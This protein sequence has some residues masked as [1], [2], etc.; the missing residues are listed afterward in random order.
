MIFRCAA[1]TFW[2]TSDGLWAAQISDAVDLQPEIGAAGNRCTQNR[3]GRRLILTAEAARLR[4]LSK[5][6]AAY[7]SRDITPRILSFT[8]Y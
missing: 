4:R 6:F 2:P 3:V 1:K 5:A 8:S 7:S